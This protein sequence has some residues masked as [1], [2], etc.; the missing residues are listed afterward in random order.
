M[1][2]INVN[3][4]GELLSP[5][6][7]LSQIMKSDNFYNVVKAVPVES[8][9]TAAQHKVIRLGKF[10]DNDNLAVELYVSNG[11]KVINFYIGEK[12]GTN[13]LLNRNRPSV[14]HG[15]YRHAS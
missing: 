10:T 8:M 14:L 4:N 3:T 2:I 5:M 11:H 1:S 9:S 12:D 13:I 6:V 7:I 15:E